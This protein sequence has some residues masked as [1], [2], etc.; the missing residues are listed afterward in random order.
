MHCAFSPKARR[1]TIKPELQ[2]QLWA[3]RGGIAFTSVLLGL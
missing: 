2:D 1:K 3:D